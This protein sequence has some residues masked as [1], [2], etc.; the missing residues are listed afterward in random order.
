MSAGGSSF[1]AASLAAEVYV[2]NGRKTGEP[3]NYSRG[4]NLNFPLI[5]ASQVASTVHSLGKLRVDW[6][7]IP[8]KSKKALSK[9]ISRTSSKMSPQ[10]FASTLQ[11]VS[12]LQALQWGDLIPVL[13]LDLLAALERTLPRMDVLDVS[14]SVSALGRLD[15]PWAD[16]P[17]A[18]QDALLRSCLRVLPHM[19][20]RGISMCVFGLGRMDFDAPA[21]RFRRELVESCS[22]YIPPRLP[23]ANAQDVASM[24]CGLGRSGVSLHSLP[25]SLQAALLA[26]LWL[27]VSSM[28]AQGLAHSLLGLSRMGASLAAIPSV[29]RVSLWSAI[30]RRAVHMNER[31]VCMTLHALGGL[32]VTASQ[33]P[34]AA[35]TDLCSVLSR[36]LPDMAT[37]VLR[38]T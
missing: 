15:A 17:D 4:V 8:L 33:V 11:G 14:S 6:A 18:L 12:K 32:G 19:D 21:S 10:G 7:G 1:P 31:E 35:I 5:I 23:K 13:Q 22:T 9:A 24:L 3:L 26:A 30:S 37:E 2:G 28:S 29:T 25:A 36:C 38:L 27:E 16:L 20:S 34:P